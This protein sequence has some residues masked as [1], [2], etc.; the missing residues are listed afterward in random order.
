M[1]GKPF[2]NTA[3]LGSYPEFVKIRE[4]WE[5]RFGKPLAAAWAIGQVLRTARRWPPRWTASRAGW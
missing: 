2:L 5:G 4:R 1:D 3:S